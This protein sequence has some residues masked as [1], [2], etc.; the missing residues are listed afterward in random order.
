MPESSIDN[1]TDSQDETRKTDS[2]TDP[3]ESLL[4]EIADSLKHGYKEARKISSSFSKELSKLIPDIDLF[5]S[6]EVMH[7]DVGTSGLLKS[8]RLLLNHRKNEVAALDIS[9]GTREFPIAGNGSIRLSE[10]PG[11]KA[12]LSKAEQADLVDR[13]Q[14]NAAKE[15]LINSEKLKEHAKLFGISDE[16]LS[17]ALRSEAERYEKA[18]SCAELIASGDLTG[19]SKMLSD[20]KAVDIQLVEKILQDSGLNI[21]AE[22]DRKGMLLISHPGDHKAVIISPEGK[23]DLI[24]ISGDKYDFDAEFVNASPEKELKSIIAK[25]SKPSEVMPT[26]I[27]HVWTTGSGNEYRSK[28]EPQQKEVEKNP[29]SVRKPVSNMDAMYKIPE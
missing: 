13:I 20:G 23:V 7:P 8:S 28:P 3:T 29:K 26:L 18:E 14:E 4:E 12:E 16:K 5:S 21:V 10:I 22:Q 25:S 15:M 19:L 1:A 17:Q 6:Q 24:G 2:P 11:S 9:V 27:R